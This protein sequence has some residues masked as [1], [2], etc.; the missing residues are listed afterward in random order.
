MNEEGVLNVAVYNVAGQL[1]DVLYNG[2]VAS[3]FHQYSWNA[4][5]QASGLYIVKASDGNRV[6]SQ[7]VMLLK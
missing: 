4:G 3:G 6:V 7:K 5:N 2:Y 1:V